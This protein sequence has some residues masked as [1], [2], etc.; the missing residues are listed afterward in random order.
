M[1]LLKFDHR[2]KTFTGLNEGAPPLKTDK[3]RLNSISKLFE[4]EAEY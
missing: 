1:K 3:A 4:G 2:T